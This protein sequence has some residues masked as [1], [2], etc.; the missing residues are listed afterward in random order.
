MPSFTCS[1][2]WRNCTLDNK[3]STFK[4]GWRVPTSGILSVDF[5]KITKPN[6]DENYAMSEGYFRAL[7]KEISA[8]DMTPARIIE[9]IKTTSNNQYFMCTH[10]IQIMR[11][12]T[13]IEPNDWFQPRVELLVTVFGR[14]MDW[15]GLTRIYDLLFPFEY[16]ILVCIPITYLS[17]GV[18][19]LVCAYACA[20]DAFTHNCAHADQTMNGAGHNY[21]CMHVPL[22]L[23]LF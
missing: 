22:V 1:R 3:P 13:N 20:L 10:I 14:T 12:F 2:S 8:E 5:V 19:E 6:P 7:L 17:S 9:S 11:F 18:A 21:M 4:R 16:Q 23:A 15:L